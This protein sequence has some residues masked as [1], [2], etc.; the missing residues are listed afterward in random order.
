MTAPGFGF[1]G[2]AGMPGA[3]PA[4]PAA[5]PV[6][7]AGSVL[8][9]P[10]DPTWEPFEM[11]DVLDL[12]GYYCF[13]ITKEAPRNDPGKSA[14]IFL[15][16]ELQDQD[17]RGKTLSRFLPDPRTAKGNVWFIWRGLMRSISGNMDFA[18]SAV[19][20]VGGMFTN[21]ICYAKVQR[22]LVNDRT[23]S[24]L[25]AWVTQAEYTAAVQGNKHRWAPR[26]VQQPSGAVG[27]LPGGTPGGFPGMGGPM[28]LP[29]GGG[30]PGAPS[31]AVPI[32]TA[33]MTPQP[34]VAYAP[35]LQPAFNAPP[36]QPAAEPPPAMAPPPVAQPV[37][38]APPAPPAPGQ[39]FSFAQFPGMGAPPA[40]NGAGAVPQPP[41]T[42]AAIVGAFPPAK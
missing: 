4:A 15:T 17:V 33:P 25:D 20:Y 32:A 11:T 23:V 13:R 18:R 34:P 29:A 27:A 21:Q 2:M 8:D 1:P 22:E 26:A 14:G 41:A 5:A 12:D 36:M 31:P 9:I 30:L 40:V 16:L 39:P 10:A 38:F 28:G 42:A 7:A 19:R 37:A 6:V 3:A 24:S 35:P